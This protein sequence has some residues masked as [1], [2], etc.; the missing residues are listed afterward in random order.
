MSERKGTMFIG[1][2]GLSFPFVKPVDGEPLI[3]I[4][5]AMKKLLNWNNEL[6]H[7]LHNYNANEKL[8][9]RRKNHFK[10]AGLIRAFANIK[11][12]SKKQ[13]YAAYGK[14]D[15][16][17]QYCDEDGDDYVDY[18][19]D[20]E[21]IEV[22]KTKVNAVD[23]VNSVDTAISLPTNFTEATGAIIQQ[24]LAPFLNF[25]REIKKENNEIKAHL[26]SLTVSNEDRYFGTNSGTI[27]RAL[28]EPIPAGYTNELPVNYQKKF[29]EVFQVHFEN[30]YWPCNNEHVRSSTL[31]FE[32]HHLDK[33][34]FEK[35]MVT[36]VNNFKMDEFTY[37]SLADKVIDIL[38]NCLTRSDDEERSVCKYSIYVRNQYQFFRELYAIM[39]YKRIPI[40][41]LFKKLYHVGYNM[42]IYDETYSVFEGDES[43]N[44]DVEDE[45][46]MPHYNDFNDEG[47]LTDQALRQQMY[48]QTRSRIY[49]LVLS[50]NTHSKDIKGFGNEIPKLSDI[51]NK[52]PKMDFTN[53][54]EKDKFLLS[55]M[56]FG[57]LE[58]P[59]P[60]TGKMFK[61]H[62]CKPTNH[63]ERLEKDLVHY[64]KD[65]GRVIIIPRHEYAAFAFDV[66][67]T[68]VPFDISKEE[69]EF[70]VTQSKYESIL[71]RLDFMET[72]QLTLYTYNYEE[73]V[74]SV[75]SVALH[76]ARTT[77]KP[78]RWY[79][80]YALY[81]NKS[82]Y[83]LTKFHNY[84]CYY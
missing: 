36:M 51:L 4:N 52:I 70:M 24:E 78:K 64:F 13:L 34:I 55:L 35:F 16:V 33:K 76:R 19:D 50:V 11:N 82:L 58:N 49:G 9:F 44:F 15:L 65:D 83:A 62:N 60:L 69:N 25:L 48:T 68:K 28:N 47:E 1:D 75:I 42:L 6:S 20:I 2:T 30:N 32:D 37:E 41:P 80:S 81:C 67:K 57:N 18:I 71:S 54:S 39:A 26:N 61:I 7:H 40:S 59:V 10:V 66:D 5:H 14:D 43:Y 21:Y 73:Y 8:V 17:F 46:F 79:I 23:T 22:S 38:Q 72:N 56:F 31:K 53:W 45:N 27:V 74:N 77:K 63:Q 12:A 29:R 3:V 84:S